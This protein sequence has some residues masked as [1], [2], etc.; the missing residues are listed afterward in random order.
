MLSLIRHIVVLLALNPIVL[1]DF[2]TSSDISKWRITDD[3]VM[4]GRSDGNFQLSAKGNGLFSGK[5]SLENN[6]GFSS[7]R[8]YLDQK[9]MQGLNKFVIRI[10]AM[11]KIIN[12]EL[13]QKEMNITNTISL[14][15]QVAIGKL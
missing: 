13:E 15:K 9:E 4:G 7:V 1:F 3:V 10:K 12:L 8:Y 5:V 11:A 14:L 2:T 6:G